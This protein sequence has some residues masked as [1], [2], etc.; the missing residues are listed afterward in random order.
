MNDSIDKRGLF[1]D[2]ALHNPNLEED[3]EFGL[4]PCTLTGNVLEDN[5]LFVEVV[6]KGGIHQYARVLN[7]FAFFSVVNSAWLSEYSANLV[8][9]VA[10]E[11]GNPEKPLLVFVSVKEDKA[12][13][14]ADWPEFA[15]IQSKVFTLFFNDKQEDAYLAFDK[16][17][18]HLGAKD[19][20]QPIP[21]GTDLK[22]SMDNFCDQVEKLCDALAALTVP[23]PVG[24]S[25]VPI[26]VA[27]INAVKTALGQLQTD[28]KK[29]LSEKSFVE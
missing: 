21:R 15:S 17:K 18:F 14:F 5:P 11:R 9:Y 28:F 8:G 6:L 16:G 1:D 23:T 22:K 19:A 24:P 10:F 7:P 4:H 2:E 26:N 20:D 29:F 3:T 25:G 13:D 27:Q 12:V